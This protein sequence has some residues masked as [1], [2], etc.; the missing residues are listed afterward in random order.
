MERLA[1][2][3]LASPDLHRSYLESGATAWPIGAEE[4]RRYALAQEA[5]MRPL[6]IQSGAKAE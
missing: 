6:V 4:Y 3:A 1:L 5:V 2:Q